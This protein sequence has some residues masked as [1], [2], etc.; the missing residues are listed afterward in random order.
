MSGKVK[1]F[2]DIK[3]HYVRLSG[4]EGDDIHRTVKIAPLDKYPF[5]IKKVRAKTGENIKL[6]FKKVKAEEKKTY[7]VSVENLKKTPGSYRDVIY[8]DTN[9]KLRPVLSL[10]V[11][12]TIKAKKPPQRIKDGISKKE[13][14]EFTFYYNEKSDFLEKSFTSRLEDIAKELTSGKLHDKRILIQGHSDNLK[15]EPESIKASFE[16]AKEI[17]D[18]LV[19][20]HGIKETRINIEGVGFEK[21]VASNKTEKGRAKNRRAVIHILEGFKSGKPKLK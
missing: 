14:P 12:G 17:K 5:K 8:I 1:K 3:P 20:Q 11:S 21:P 16:R 7:E 9:S 10:N 19:D 4:T 6:S 15:P 13:M 2:A 18:I